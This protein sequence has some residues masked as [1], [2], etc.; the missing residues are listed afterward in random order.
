MV[1]ENFVLFLIAGFFLVVSGIYLVKSL[2]KISRSL[3]ISEFSSAFILMA[4][5]TSIP[6]L[7]VGISS[8]LKNNPAL[9]LGN[10]MGANIIDLSLITG[11]FAIIGKKIKFNPKKVG[12]SIYFRFASIILLLVLY[13]IGNSLSRIDGL[14]LLSLFGFNIFYLVRKSKRYSAKVK[15]G[16]PHRHKLQSVIVL[17]VSLLVLFLSSRYVVEYAQKIAQDVGLSEIFIGLFLISFATTLPEF[18]FG[19]NAI[20]LNH[21]DMSIGDQTGTVFANICL[22]TGI[23]AVLHP[24]TVPLVPFLVSGIFMLIT[25]TFV[26]VFIHSS[27]KMTIYEGIALLGLYILFI[28]VQGVATLLSKI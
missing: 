25:G 21:K 23:V 18:I 6:E 2:N 17:I 19:I 11:L 24:I 8:A 15:K 16:E 26:V 22:I 10:V 12:K 3:G 1:I 28:F 14:I 13:L 7:L 27:K 4:F 9:S 5:A 20:L